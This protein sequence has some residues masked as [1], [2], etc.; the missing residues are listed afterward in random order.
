MNRKITYL[1]LLLLPAICCPS[2]QKSGE[3]GDP[4]G[5]EVIFTANRTRATESFSYENITIVAPGYGTNAAWQRLPYRAVDG[6][7]IPSTA[8]RIRWSSK[9]MVFAAWSSPEGVDIDEGTV[10]FSKDLDML[11]GA[12]KAD[13]QYTQGA[14]VPVS[15]DFR[16]LVGKLSIT[17]IDRQ[18]LP[19]EDAARQVSVVFPAIPRTGFITTQLTDLPRVTNGASG[20]ELRVQLTGSGDEDRGTVYLPPLTEDQLK[21]YG[22]FNIRVNT[23]DYVGTLNDMDT[24]GIG[25]GDHIH[26]TFLINDDHTAV[27]QAITVAPWDSYPTNYYS[28]PSP[29]I[30]AVDDLRILSRLVNGEGEV[31]EKMRLEDFYAMEG[32]KRV[33]R[34]YTDIAFEN[35]DGFRP[36]GTD[37]RPF[38]DL[39][40]DG[41]GYT[42]SGLDFSDTGSDHVELFGVVEDA[43]ILDVRLNDIY[44]EG[45]D[46]VGGLVGMTRGVTNL[47]HCLVSGGRVLGGDNVGGLVGRAASGTVIRNCGVNIGT[48]SGASRLGG[49][50][51]D[52]A[53]DVKNCYSIASSG[54]SSN[55]VDIGGFVGR[56]TA[57]GRI[58]NCYSSARFTNSATDFCGALAGS[59]LSENRVTRCRW[60]S[61]AIDNLLCFKA[62]G[63]NASLSPDGIENSGRF[64]AEYDND[65]SRNLCDYLNGNIADD[66]LCSRWIALYGVELPLL[67]WDT[68]INAN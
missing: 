41:N 37:S 30:W 7:L 6:Q 25:A 9:N 2:C 5:K 1:L 56:N 66:P 3:S 21:M 39:V 67:R 62:V 51:G 26:V 54:I 38:S 29:G 8:D 14:A 49:F 34:L 4:V 15:L 47:D 17:V 32:E 12:Q 11:I 43:T 58:D 52:N 19:G 27:L 10:D 68:A 64:G 28:R 16:H 55:E 36:M 35:G 44:M 61:S 45:R 50:V 57:G 31:V 20:E 24:D 53:G 13:V 23:T 60:N 63:N 40:F 65:S 48:A 46:C 22:T 59:D 18:R 42:I 33:I